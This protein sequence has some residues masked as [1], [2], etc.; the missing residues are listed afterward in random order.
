MMDK[1][2]M[3][4]LKDVGIKRCALSGK[5]LDKE[6]FEPFMSFAVTI[7]AIREAKDGLGLAIAEWMRKENVGIKIETQEEFEAREKVKND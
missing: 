1:V 3:Q 7:K 2:W 5:E 6:P 4:R